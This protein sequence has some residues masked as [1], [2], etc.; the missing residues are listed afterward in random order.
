MADNIPKINDLQHIAIV[1]PGLLGGS[2]ALGLKSAG[3]TARITGIGH[4]QTSIDTALR[5]GAIDAG[6]LD[7][8]ATADAQLI[9]IATPIGLFQP[10]LQ[11]L[12]NI[13]GPSAV[14]TD[15]GSTKRRVC[16]LAAKYLPNKNLFVGSH[17]MAGSEK[18][19]VEFARADLCHNATCILTPTRSTSRDA[20]ALVESVWSA[21]GMRLVHLTPDPHDRIL[22]K[23]SHLPHVL[24]SA[25]VNLCTDS[26]LEVSGPGFLDTTRVASG[27][28]NLWHDIID[29]N[30]DHLLAATAALRKQLDRLDAAVRSGRSAQIRQFLDAAKQKRDRLVQFKLQ[31]H[32]FEP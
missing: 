2:I 30:A 19:G 23:I 27:D 18:R 25:L 4:R 9:L 11:R 22:A 20:L 12:A 31:T 29:S 15:V 1:G 14:V 6:S 13:I 8:A 3:L 26:E 17:P 21:L 32:R 10:T 7:L 5:I 28:V 24:A 16:Q